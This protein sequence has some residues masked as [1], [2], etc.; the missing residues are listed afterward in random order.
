LS[1]AT[2]AALPADAA[3]GDLHCL[4]ISSMFWFT[5]TYGRVIQWRTIAV[6]TTE[7]EQM[8]LVTVARMLEAGAEP[9]VPISQLAEQLA[10]QPVSATQMVHHLEESG[11]L[12]Y[13]PYKG[14]ALTPEGEQMA[15]RILRHR[16]LWEVFLVKDLGLSPV[17]ADELACALEHVIPPVVAE[18]LSS[19]LGH[20][21]VSPRGQ[22]IPATVSAEVTVSQISIAALRVGQQ[23]EVARIDADAAGRAF[24][25]QQGIVIGTLVVPLAA[26]SDGAL[27]VRAG[28]RSVFLSAD[29]ARSLWV[30]SPDGSAHS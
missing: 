28:E 23:G 2:M 8:Y 30:R 29:F 27:L 25:T 12:T 4:S 6:T 11:L 18:Q 10:I 9:P 22:P 24:L 20:P 26:G 19:F 5:C 14:V 17:D 21:T 1:L 13:A 7:H 15:V 3:H 16:R